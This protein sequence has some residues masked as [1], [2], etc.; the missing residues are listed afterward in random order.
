MNVIENGRLF[1]NRAVASSDSLGKY[2]STKDSF[3][4]SKSA[5]LSTMGGVS[6]SSEIISEAK[7]GVGDSSKQNPL[8]SQV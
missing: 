2:G 1:I 8:R 4:T 7:E 5:E 3:S 6:F